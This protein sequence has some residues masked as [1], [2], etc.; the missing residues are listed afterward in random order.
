MPAP[1]GTESRP[2]ARPPHSPDELLSA[3][4]EQNRVRTV[5]AAVPA[6]E[7]ALLLLRSDGCSY[8]EMAATLSLNPASVGT[9][10]VRARGA[11]RKEY[12]RRYGEQ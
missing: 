6:R 11:F 12:V 2:W 5:L 8:D 4:R 9:L 1:P 3:A 10:L 7:A